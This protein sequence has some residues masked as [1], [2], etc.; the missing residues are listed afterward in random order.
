MAGT[1]A[2]ARKAAITNR[3]RYGEDFYG[4]IGKKG[5]QASAHSIKTFAK[6]PELAKRASRKAAEARAIKKFP[7]L[8]DYELEYEVAG[9]S[10]SG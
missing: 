4:V 6:D 5:G 7:S 2:G 1:K 3:E 8:E 10:E 9:G